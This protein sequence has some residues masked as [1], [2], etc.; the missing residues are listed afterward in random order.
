[1]RRFLKNIIGKLIERI[2]TYEYR[3]LSLDEDDV[4]KKILDTRQLNNV[5]VLSDTGYVSAT[6]VHKTQPYRV[7][8][9]TLEN[10]ER[11]EC[12]DN[13]IV[14]TSSLEEIFVK[15]LAIDDEVMTKF[16]SVK[17][18]S[19]YKCPYKMS[20]Y[21][22]SI[23]SPNHRYYTNNILSHNTT[24]VAS[25]L[26][27]MLVFH[28]DRN[29]LV[30]ANKEK[31]AIE[32]V[33]KIINIF[34]GLP[35]FMKP[36]C[37]NFGKMGLKLENG[38]QLMCSAT[39]NTASIGF[40]IHCILLDEF[41][42]IPENIVNN[43]WRSVYPTL[44]SSQVSQCIITST[45]NGT[46]N[47][48]Y[49]IWSKSLEKKNSFVNLRTDYY[50]VPGHDDAWAA[51]M[52]ADFGE[53]EFAQEFQ[54]QFNINSSM[55]A[56]AEDL[57]FMQRISKEFVHKDIY[58]DNSY[59]NNEHL[60]WHPD[61]DPNDID[62][63]DKFIFLVDLAEGGNEEDKTFKSKKKEPD[64]NAVNIFKVH[65]NSIANMRKYSE[66]SC[67]IQDAFK[68]VQVGKYT[69]NTEDEVYCAKICSALAYD[70]MND[71]ERDSVRIMVEMNFNG[72][73]Y[74][75]AFRTHP[76]YSDSTI[77]RTY[78]T[79]PVPGERQRRHLGFKT[80]ANKEYFCIKG[81]KMINMKR[82]V[83]TDVKTY[84]QVQAFGY[85]KGKLMGIA[86]HDD[87]SMPVFNHIPRMLDDETFRSWL[88]EILFDYSDENKKYQINQL[89][90]KWDM[91]NPETSDSEFKS[92][93]D[94]PDTYDVAQPNPYNTAN[95]PQCVFNAPTTYN[96]IGTLKH[97]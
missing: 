6:E 77:Q 23:D 17:V 97:I 89:I 2:E 9:V 25:F 50:E 95:M 4:S 33:D 52:K 37:V 45:P 16:G 39:T 30:V 66:R 19:I 80:T 51:R 27:W 10:G 35:Y 74:T 48:F 36:G 42:H 31:T 73:S 72:K 57:A 18:K 96:S 56:K 44:S 55:L 69:S 22:I 3:N 88:E 84:Q 49:E 40:T 47:K 8:E 53:E 81:S 82:I 86:C 70:L 61:F 85:I 65:V 63:N 62:E 38:S 78:H 26:S 7:Y 28:A 20:M 21:D 29:I 41:A 75:N 68:Y 54:L 46:T 93:Y 92:M 43:F 58:V 90:E 14:F 64:Y 24:T 11:F 12:A 94:V 5:K 59:L 15:D 67:Q 71:D 91:N 34:R 32:I 83:V 76:R 1:M 13:H 79:K 60:V 87:L